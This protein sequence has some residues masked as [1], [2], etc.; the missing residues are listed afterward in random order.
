[1]GRRIKFPAS[2]SHPQESAMINALRVLVS[3]EEGQD[4]IEY[5]LI[6]GF[7]SVIC[8]LVIIAT[9]ESVS[10]LWDVIQTKVSAAAASM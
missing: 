9:G 3:N 5:G 8:Y 6:A 4:L 2:H 1:M 10:A 7:I